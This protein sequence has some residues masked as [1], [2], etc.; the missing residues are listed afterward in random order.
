M[1]A[2][3]RLK[4]VVLDAPDIAGLSAFYTAL[5]GW[6]QQYADDG[7]IT[8][9]SDDGWRF[10]L[11]HA[12]DHVPPRW[13]DPQFPQQ[14]HLDVAVPDI[15]AAAERAQELG[16]QRS[17]SGPTW[18][19][20]TDPAGHPLDLCQNKDS[21]AVKV[22]AVTIDCP[23]A[24]A[25]STFYADLLGMQ[26]RYEGDEGALIGAD[27]QGQIMFQRVAQYTPPAWPDPAHPQQFHLDLLVE[28]VQAATAAALAGGATTLPGSGDNWRVLA[29]PAG[30]PFCLVWSA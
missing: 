16:A 29:D 14:F 9:T 12:G 25:L 11:Q 21:D 22:F 20:V 5:L 7:W 10:G 17:G 26:V 13:P 28:D 8:L 1:A 18:H 27:G 4:T 2:P 24:K 19:T 30:H 6:H 3:A 23:D 15:D